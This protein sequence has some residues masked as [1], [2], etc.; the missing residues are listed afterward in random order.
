MIE[1]TLE[2][3]D[4]IELSSSQFEGTREGERELLGQ[5]SAQISHL[6]TNKL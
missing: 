6:R 5:S 4:G 1:G 3:S 2:R